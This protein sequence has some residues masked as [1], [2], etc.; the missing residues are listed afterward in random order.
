MVITEAYYS[1]GYKFDARQKPIF[2]SRVTKYAFITSG[3]LNFVILVE[4]SDTGVPSSII[5]RM[6][7]LFVFNSHIVNF[8]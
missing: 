8:V 1:G 5:V 2:D 6:E 4:D 3:D 7:Y